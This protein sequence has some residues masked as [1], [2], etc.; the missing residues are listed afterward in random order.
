MADDERKKTMLSWQAEPKFEEI[1]SLYYKDKKPLY[2]KEAIENLIKQME[3][4]GGQEGKTVTVQGLDGKSVK[5]TLEKVKK[6]KDSKGNDA[7]QYVRAYLLQIFGLEAITD[8]YGAHQIC[9]VH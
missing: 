7:I 9:T 2:T 3:D 1:R 6:T 4:I 5:F 8:V